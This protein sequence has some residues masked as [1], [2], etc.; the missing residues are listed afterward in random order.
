MFLLR[1]MQALKRMEHVLT[2][3]TEQLENTQS[4]YNDLQGQVTSRVLRCRTS[5]HLSFNIWG[6]DLQLS[7]KYS[8]KPQREQKSGGKRVSTSRKHIKYDGELAVA[9]SGPQ[10]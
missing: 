4:I 7:K 8:E 9:L 5:A 6:F 3:A 10:M 2:L 1:Q